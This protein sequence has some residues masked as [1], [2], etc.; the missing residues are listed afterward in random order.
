MHQLHSPR[1]IMFSL[2]LNFAVLTPAVFCRGQTPT[3]DPAV[4]TFKLPDQMVWTKEA[5]GAEVCI[6]LGD[7]KKA[8]TYI[9]L[10]KWLPHRMSQPHWHPHDRYITV[11]S[12]TWWVGTGRVFDP[13]KTTPMRPG[14][15]VTH[16]GQQIHY[17]GAKDEE[18][19]IEIV[20]EGPATITLADQKETK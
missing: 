7:P 20:G 2:L 3:P 6:L 1:R 4:L 12:G 19:I 10:V 13:N 14:S 18:A 8:G 17:D 15:F 11:L 5:S 16:F 9:E